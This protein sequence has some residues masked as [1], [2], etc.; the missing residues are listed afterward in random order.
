MNLT[1]YDYIKGLVVSNKAFYLNKKLKKIVLNVHPKVNK[2]QVKSALETL[3]NIK[4]SK[5]NILIR[6]GKRKLLKKSGK[7]TVQL[8]SVKRAIVTLAEG[9]TFDLFDKTGANVTDV[10]GQYSKQAEKV[11]SKLLAKKGARPLV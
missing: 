9:Y 2:V 3:F 7:A 8:P 6:K 4:V 5:V 11:K 10:L 1:I